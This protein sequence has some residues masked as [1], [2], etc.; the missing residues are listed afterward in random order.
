MPFV[1]AVVIIAL[2]VVLPSVKP[3]TTN[4][5]QNGGSFP[6]QQFVKVSNQEYALS[7]NTVEVYLVSWE[8]CPYGATQSWPLF[9]P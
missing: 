1:I 9:W 8:G 5:T 3:P 6:F 4:T 7:P 2:V